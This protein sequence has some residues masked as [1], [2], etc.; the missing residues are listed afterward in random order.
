LDA[1]RPRSRVRPFILV[2]LFALIAAATV[3][4]FALSGPLGDF[5]LSAEMVR[6]RIQSWGAWGVMG[7][8]ALMIAHSFVPFPAE[9]LAMA[10]GMVYGLFWGTAVT[11]IG[12]MAG[13]FLAFGLAR[14]LGRPFV[15]AV[16]SARGRASLDDWV[17]RQG[18]GT[19]L[20]SR[21]I[22]VIS[23][24][25]I[26]Y[27]AGLTRIGWLT[28]AWATGLGILPLTVL[29][30]YMGDRMM[31]GETVVWI[32][33]L[34]VGV[35]GWLAWQGAARSIRRRRARADTRER[36]IPAD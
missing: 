21:F 11:W 12:A 25:L 31:S 10:N 24:N 33:L 36:E 26:N 30:V 17:K 8:I 23:F 1:N 28:F 3:G 27:A 32:W 19:L 29:M 22:P 20:F 13:A 16:V 9:I 6:D 15:D 34:V 18:A 35:V 7:S 4:T 5:E 2:L 14:W